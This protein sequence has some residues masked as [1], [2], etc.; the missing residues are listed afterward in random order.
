MKVKPSQI[1]VTPNAPFA[2]DVLGRE[3]HIK[4][5]VTLIEQ[6][7][8]PVVV[9]INGAW[10]TGKTTYLRMMDAEL[11]RREL[12][13][14]LYNAWENDYLSDPFPSIASEIANL[15]PAESSAREKLLESA[16]KILKLSIPAAFKALTSGMVDISSLSDETIDSA[17]TRL[18]KRDLHSYLQS[19]T[20]VKEFRERL[21]N[22][23]DE[24]SDGHSQ[25][26]VIVD[27]LDRCR[28]DFAVN[29]LEVAKHL[30]EVPRISF[31][32]GLHEKQIHSSLRA[33]YGAG[34]DAAAYL[35]RIIDLSFDLPNPTML[36]YYDHLFKSLGLNALL[37]KYHLNSGSTS[38]IRF[39][40]D[41]V[42][43]LASLY[44]F[45]LRDLEKCFLHIAIVLSN[46]A[47][48]EE[49]FPSMLIFLI[50][51]HYQDRTMY[52]R[53]VNK[54]CDIEE[55]IEYFKSIEGGFVFVFNDKDH[56]G[57]ILIQQLAVFIH[58]REKQ[59]S[60]Y[61]KLQEMAERQE[62]S[63][64]EKRILKNMVEDAKQ[65]RH[66]RNLDRAMRY[67]HNMIAFLETL[68]TSE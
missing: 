21:E 44:D 36:R 3:E 23:V 1:E 16:A 9:S 52:A 6:S 57:P 24:I 32:L 20:D 7:D 66:G 48:K 54:D 50:M 62:T 60:A 61:D 35:R 14:V 51:L 11:R 56:T 33:V 63:D 65:V 22:V 25:L 12:R 68:N 43:G 31:V 19:Q 49:I 13:C 4:N 5:M 53:I 2:N 59:E 15:A 29:V 64:F 17:M 30:F 38:E 10:G 67:L 45:S 37:E 26:V 41:L 40:R 46:F 55:V 8:E 47:E 28:P 27:E 18:A 39:T 58:D 34:M 42:L